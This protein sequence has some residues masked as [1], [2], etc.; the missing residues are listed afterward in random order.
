MEGTYFNYTS[1]KDDL[2]FGGS[3]YILANQGSVYIIYSPGAN[4]TLGIKS[5][6]KGKYTLKWY[7]CKTG[8]TLE[9]K[10]EIEKKDHY[11]WSIPD[12]MGKEV[13]LYLVSDQFT[14]EHNRALTK[15]HKTAKTLHADLK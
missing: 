9:S 12:S 1:P 2:A 8:K 3:K 11:A 15:N 6:P 13:A 7:D 14:K 5:I 4:Q 10:L